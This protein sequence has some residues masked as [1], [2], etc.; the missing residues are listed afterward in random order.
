MR[1]GIKFS[2]FLEMQEKNKEHKRRC[3]QERR[4]KYRHKIYGEGRITLKPYDFYEKW[5]QFGTI[6][7]DPEDDI[8]II[9]PVRIS[10]ASVSI[11]IRNNT[12]FCK[13]TVDGKESQYAVPMG[14]ICTIYT[15]D[16]CL[17]NSDGQ[18]IYIDANNGRRT[19]FTVEDG[20]YVRVISNDGVNIDLD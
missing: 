3:N 13:Q 5:E 20:D 11:S 9:N 2:G 17:V 4:K 18:K 15:E 7:P 12:V 16:G 19:T 1:F 6:E 14:G 10:T 8:V